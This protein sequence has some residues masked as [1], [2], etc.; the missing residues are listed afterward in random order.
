MTF[1]LVC[2]ICQKSFLSPTNRICCSPKCKHMKLSIDYKESGHPNWKG[3]RV[4]NAQGYVMIKQHGHPEADVNNYVREHRLIMERHLGKPLNRGDDVHHINGNR[5]DNR[6]ENLILLSRSA[7]GRHHH[8]IL[9][10]TLRPLPKCLGLEWINRKSHY[11][12]YIVKRC[13]KC[14]KLFWA[15]TDYNSHSCS[16]K[17]SASIRNQKS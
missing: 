7:H 6:I 12:K 13:L 2:C 8:P 3:G 11:H 14:N 10:R 9:P 15:R 17:C 16:P 1:R 4:L 5:Q